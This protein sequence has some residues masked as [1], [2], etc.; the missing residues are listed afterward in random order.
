MTQPH[1]LAEV[2]HAPPPSRG[3]EYDRFAM[4]RVILFSDAVYAIIIT[5]LALDVRLPEHA[6]GMTL[7]AQLVATGP[8]LGAYALSFI[9]VATLWRIHLKRFR[10]LVAI[11][12]PLVGG[13]LLQLLLTGLLPFSTSVIA[14]HVGTLAVSLYAGNIVAISIAARVTWARAL[15]R[16][17]LVSPELTPA[18]RD[19]DRRRT[20][21]T[22]AVFGG[23][24]VVAQ[25]YPFAAPFCWTLLLPANQGLNLLDRRRGRS[26]PL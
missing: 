5:L 6:E 25:F 8:K 22:I 16:P 12:A 13:N 19:D 26:A 9:V 21:V 3:L 11:D 23:S 2:V 20:L 10:Y 14:T 24:I 4:E 17:H 1:D 18:L 15:Q 7:A